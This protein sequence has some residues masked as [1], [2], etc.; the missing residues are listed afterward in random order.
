MY[1]QMLDRLTREDV[2]LVRTGLGL[3]GGRKLIAGARSVI[4]SGDC[5]KVIEEGG[6]VIGADRLHMGQ[7]IQLRRT[8]SLEHLQGVGVHTCNFGA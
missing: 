4:P 3:Y 7:S 2:L 1:L 8:I 6:L 5:A